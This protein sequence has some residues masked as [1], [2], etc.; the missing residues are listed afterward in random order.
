MSNPK[1]LVDYDVRV[2][3]RN[4]STGV[5]G[6]AEVDAYLAALP[7]VGSNAQSMDVQVPGAVREVVE[8]EEPEAP[9]PSAAPAV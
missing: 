5:L 1:K 9:E 2:R 3:E 7:D 8:P 6:K 4:L